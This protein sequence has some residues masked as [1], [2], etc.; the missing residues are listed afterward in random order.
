MEHMIT[1]ALIKN[2]YQS[3]LLPVPEDVSKG[4]HQQ[5]CKLFVNE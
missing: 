4:F 3:T 5:H 1:V 2:T